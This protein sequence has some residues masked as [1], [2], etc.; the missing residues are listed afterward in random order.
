M[1]KVLRIVAAIVAVF[2]TNFL[3]LFVFNIL[4][5]NLGNGLFANFLGVVAQI[6]TFIAGLAFAAKVE[7]K[8]MQDY[9]I[10]WSKTDPRNMATGL[11]LG[12][13]TFILVSAPIYFTGAYKLNNTSYSWKKIMIQL[14]VFIGVGFI[15]EYFCRGF[16]QHQLLR[17]GPYVALIATAIIFSLLHLSNPGMTLMAFVNLVLAACFMGSVMYAFNSIHAAIGVHITWNW[18]QGS[19]FGIP[20]SGT[21]SSGYFLTT[22]VGKNDLVT[23]GRFGAE[24]SISCTAVL[25]ILTVVLLFIA[26]RNGNLDQFFREER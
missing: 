13:V 15:E 22:V 21:T 10:I 24:A 5:S 9:G 14:V 23:G 11:A 25:L 3:G 26:K 1:K 18:V 16:L 4:S 19:I 8:Q 2:G 12:I 17:F 7:G 6:A 20:V